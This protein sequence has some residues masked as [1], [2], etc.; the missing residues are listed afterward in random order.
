MPRMIRRARFTPNDIIRVLI[1]TG[2]MW[3]GP[4][5]MNNL[6]YQV[7]LYFFI[8][9][10]K[11]RLPKLPGPSG[12]HWLSNL[13]STDRNAAYLADDKALFL[14]LTPAADYMDPEGTRLAKQR[15]SRGGGASPL[16][17]CLFRRSCPNLILNQ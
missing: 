2:A 6:W 7:R 9:T 5:L 14:S 3:L 11:M 15:R 8:A 10:Q 1:N 12:Y 4:V 17:R 13:D 16:N